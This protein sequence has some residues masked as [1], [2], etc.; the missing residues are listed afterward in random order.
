MLVLHLSV[1]VAGPWRV[2][3]RDL[4]VHAR[5]TPDAPVLG[6]LV[7]HHAFA[8]RD[9]PVP[10]E[11]RGCE[12]WVPV[13]PRGWVCA[14]EVEES[15][16]EPVDLPVLL[17][18]APPQPVDFA[19]Y[20]RTGTYTPVATSPLLPFVYGRV[21]KRWR[22]REWASVE[23]WLAKAKPVGRLP[24]GRRARFVAV[25]ETERGVLFERAN[26]RFV[27]AEDVYEFPITRFQGRNLE[28]QPL[29]EGRSPAWVVAYD[30]LELSGP[31]GA[32]AMP[33][34]TSFEVEG[35]AR[36]GRYAAWVDGA[37]I[38]APDDGTIRVWIPGKRPSEVGDDVLWL[39]VDTETQTLALLRGDEPLYVTLVSTGLRGTPTPAGLYRISDKAAW[40]DMRSR[41]GSSDPYHV[42]A[43]PWVLHFKPR[44]AL[45]G[46]YWHWGFGHRASHGCVNLASRDADWLFDHLA[47]E[48]PT[49]WHSV[50]V[51]E[52]EH[53]TWMRVR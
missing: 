2:A 40:A 42:E 34:H 19:S 13:E 23:A 8:R 12:S 45:H 31:D 32:V 26:G 15:P 22:G 36:D 49:G 41:A 3:P 47:P 39:D 21:W 44:Y 1:A 46:A 4:R 35:P 52:G 38:E 6:G 53:G 43:V 7:A 27:P 37:R 48:L 18:H 17:D 29:V 11:A 10:P 50:R 20:L 16:L 14:P 5:P 33:Y 30:G 28:E 9:E 24:S 25:H 51:G